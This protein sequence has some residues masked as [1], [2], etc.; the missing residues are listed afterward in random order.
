MKQPTHS[1]KQNPLN[2][3]VLGDALPRWGGGFSRTMARGILR[4]LGWRFAGSV[5]NLPKMVLIGAPHTS[6]W[7]FP[8][9]MVLLFALQVRVYWL[10]KHTFVN[11][12]LK[13]LLLWLGG[14]PVDR[15]AAF[16]VVGQTVEQFRQRDQFLLG[17]A[18]E[19]TRSFV[20]RWKMGFFYI[21]QATHVPILP[22][23]LDYGRKTIALGDPIWPEV[24]ETAV[25]TQL[26]AFYKGVQGKYPEQFSVESIRPSFREG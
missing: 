19:G 5:P 11:G 10:G 4:L 8:L 22:V 23:A 15:R 6:N 20:P 13:P 12:P 2:L 3:P 9:A 26:R 24:G 16:G 7:D 18:P 14:V 17:L 21:A 1:A 25:L